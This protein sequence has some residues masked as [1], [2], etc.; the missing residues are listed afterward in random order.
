MANNKRKSIK[1]ILAISGI[2]YLILF[3]LVLVFSK[4]IGGK[5]LVINGTPSLPGYLYLLD[6]NSKTLV[7][8]NV[9]AA[10]VPKNDFVE[11]RH[12]LK[13]VWGLPGDDVDFDDY[14]DFFINGELKGRAKRETKNGQLP[15]IHSKSGAIKPNYYFLG[16]PHKDS[17]DSRYTYIGNIHEKNI[18]GDARLIF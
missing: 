17:F 8:G 11:N 12:F 14:G 6:E 1:K 4:G 10:T 2:V 13:Q 15:L 5:R 9:V 18:I 7:K 3:V 16:T